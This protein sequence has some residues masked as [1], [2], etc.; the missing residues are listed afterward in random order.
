MLKVGKTFYSKKDSI[1]QLLIIS[2]YTCR[3]MQRTNG[4]QGFI[5]DKLWCLKRP[6]IRES[7]NK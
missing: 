4:T 7:S 2:L 3:S 6:N 1:L 5:K